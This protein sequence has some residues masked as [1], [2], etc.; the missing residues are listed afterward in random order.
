S[1]VAFAAA[2]AIWTA[3]PA[4]AD[5]I[6]AQASPAPAAS[7]APKA[8]AAPA[9]P[10]ATSAPVPSPSPSPSAPPKPFTLS[11]YADVGYTTAHF[12]TNAV[13]LYPSQT[14]NCL[15]PPAFSQSAC[16][17]Q[18]SGRVF[19]TLNNQLQFHT[20]NLTA[21]LLPQPVGFTFEFNAGND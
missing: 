2:L 15:A 1:V 4:R 9:A 13:N 10:A 20:F 19:D 11:G 8:S 7:S 5:V 17:N 16:Q 6:V 14:P 21:V 18:I 3:P 12:S